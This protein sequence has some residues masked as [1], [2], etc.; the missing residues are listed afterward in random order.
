MNIK[1][2]WKDPDYYTVTYKFV[3]I[4][5]ILS[6]YSAA[7]VDEGGN[8]IRVNLRDLQVVDKNYLPK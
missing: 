7:V 3:T 8:I 6:D 1:A 4:I 5:D 2:L